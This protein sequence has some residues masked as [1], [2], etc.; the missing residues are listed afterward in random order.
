MKYTELDGVVLTPNAI[1]QLKEL[2]M[3]GSEIVNNFTSDIDALLDVVL[4]S[5]RSGVF[6]LS[7]AQTLRQ[8]HLLRDLKSTLINLK[9]PEDGI[10]RQ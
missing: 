3:G 10:R 6:D 2:Q 4:D 7:E 9:L 8:V 5:S 1:A